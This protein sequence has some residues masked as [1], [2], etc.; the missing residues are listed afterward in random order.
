VEVSIMVMNIGETAKKQVSSSAGQLGGIPILI[1]KE[2]AQRSRG[3]EA[4]SSNI[5]AAKAVAGAVKTTLGPKGMDKMLVNTT[6]DVIITGDGATILKEM[7]IEH[8]AA[9]MI[10]EVA[11]TQ[12]EEVGDGTTTAVIIT[13]ELLS[14]A[15]ELFD[16]GVHPTVIVRGYRLAAEESKKVLDGLAMDVSVEQEDQEDILMNIA[17]TAIRGREDEF[18]KK[19]LARIAVRAVKA[20]ADISN[21]READTRDI[22]IEKIEGGSIDDTEL[23]RGVVIEKERASINMPRKMENARILLLK[24]ALEIKKTETKSKINI[25]TPEQLMHFLVQEEKLLE[26]MVSRIGNTGANVVFCSKGIDDVASDYLA[27]S[28]ILAV[29]NISDKDIEK[30]SR[31]TEAKILADLEGASEKDLGKSCFIEEKK[32]GDKKFIF[33]RDC[34][35]PKSVSILLRGGTKHVVESLE[36]T[37]ND[38]LRVVGAVIEDGKFVAGGGSSEV[39][40]AL[41][42][43]EYSASLTGREQLAVY[44]FAEAIDIVPKT[45]A[46]NAGLDSI[47]MLVELRSQHEQGNKNAGLDVYSGRVVDMA[48]EGIIEPLRVKTQAIDSATEAAE[49]ILRIDDVISAGKEK[50]PA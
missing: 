4:Q 13:G 2:G 25:D 5:S 22:K 37:L 40:V 21:G 6:G 18:T 19:K 45:L 3:K 7:D 36:I 1:L 46:E 33:V 47:N 26:D 38:A 44:K 11:K 10:V 29:K 41:R 42:L 16:M 23:I 24:K 27:K 31:A 17:I 34:S 48:A 15:E 9:K 8:P 43:R 49:M 30:I 32:I 28:G 39:E 12:E 35:N 50:P 14:K 20:V